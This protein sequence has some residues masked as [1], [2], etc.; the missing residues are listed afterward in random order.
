MSTTLHYIFDPLCGWCYG[1]SNSLEELTKVN[2]IYLKL[3]P[4]GLY[5]GSG[6]FPMTAEMATKIAREDDSIAVLSGNLFTNSYKKNVLNNK[7]TIFDSSLPTLAMSSVALTAPHKEWLLL[8]AVQ[9]ARFILG[10]DVTNSEYLLHLIKRLGFKDAAREFETRSCRLRIFNIN[11][12][13]EAQ[14]LM[15]HF[16]IKRT[17]AFILES[18]QCF[19]K[20]KVED[21]L[22]DTP[23]FIEKIYCNHLK[24]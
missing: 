1:A 6:D 7:K 20:I 24:K 19:E 9:Y 21:I 5:S 2:T 12:M 22:S 10:D 4:S 13:T 16:K 3:L 15:H 14:S 11:R 18:H 23:S 17:P 8:K